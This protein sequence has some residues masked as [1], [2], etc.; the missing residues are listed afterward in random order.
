M[1]PSDGGRWGFNTMTREPKRVFVD[2]LGLQK[3]HRHS[4]K[5][6]PANEKQMWNLGQGKRNKKTE[7]LGGP[8]P[9]GPANGRFGTRGIGIKNL[10][11]KQFFERHVFFFNQ[12]L[13]LLFLLQI[14]MF[15][16]RKSV[17]SVISYISVFQFVLGPGHLFRSC[18]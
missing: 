7:L 9:C 17:S 6:R 12:K 11:Q 10:H 14:L 4:T 15:T 16:V 2:G 3:H 5:R 8:A 18:I 1:A 13:F